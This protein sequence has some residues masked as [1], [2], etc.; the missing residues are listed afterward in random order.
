MVQLFLAA[1]SSGD[2]KLRGSHVILLAF[3]RNRGD[4][5]LPIEEIMS[6]P[7][8]LLFVFVAVLALPRPASPQTDPWPR[9]LPVLEN[10]ELMNLMIRPAYDVLRQVLEHPPADRKA[11]AAIYQQAA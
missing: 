2:E 11:W 9:P 10:V 7:R 3:A 5:E 1:D 6:Q 8:M 4:R